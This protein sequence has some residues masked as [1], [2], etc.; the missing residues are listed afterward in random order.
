MRINEIQPGQTYRGAA[1][2]RQIDFTVERLLPRYQVQFLLKI[3]N[4]DTDARR[5]QMNVET[6]ARTCRPVPEC[7]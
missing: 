1:N 3:V 4:S 6:F 7:H 2:G 5:A